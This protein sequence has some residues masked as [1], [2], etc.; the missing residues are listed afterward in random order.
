MLAFLYEA[1]TGFPCESV[2]QAEDFFEFPIFILCSLGAM[3]V[4]IAIV[5]LFF[6]IS[7]HLDY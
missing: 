1:I 6:I 3:L 4:I 2:E 5:G 7:K